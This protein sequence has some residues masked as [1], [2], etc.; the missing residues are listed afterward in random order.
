MGGERREGLSGLVIDKFLRF[1]W[2]FFMFY[3][4]K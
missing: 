2:L 4:S 1:Y 3:L